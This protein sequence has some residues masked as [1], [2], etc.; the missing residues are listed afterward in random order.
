MW[1]PSALAS[2]AGAYQRR[3]IRIVEAQHRIS[4]NRLAGSAPDQELLEALADEVKPLL[5]GSARSL[6]WLLASPFRYGLGRPSRFRAADVLPGI[7]YASEDIETAVT[8]AAYWRLVAFSR[9]PGFQRPRTPTPMSAFS[10]TVQ[11]SAALDLLSGR[12]VEDEASWTDPADYTATQALAANARA[13]GVQVIRAPSARRRGGVNAAV[14]DAS[15]L[16]PP[17]RPH[18]SWAFLATGD[19]LLATREMSNMAMRFT[20]ESFG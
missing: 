19:G 5:P 10:V 14:L 16:R 17:P 15:A 18:S 13:A 4:T 11:A 12:F 2:E 3:V 1:T 8:E 9:S 20:L 6:P 7:F